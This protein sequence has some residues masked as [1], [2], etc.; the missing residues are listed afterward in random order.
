MPSPPAC[1]RQASRALSTRLDRLRQTFDHLHDQL[2]DAVAH[3]IGHTVA[4]AVREAVHC[5]LEQ[6]PTGYQSPAW[7]PPGVSSRN[8]LW[9]DEE[10]DPWADHTER[11]RAGD[12]TSS[13]DDSE[14]YKVTEPAKANLHRAVLVGCEAAAYWLRQ[15]W[16]QLPLLAAF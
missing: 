3:Q 8:P 15:R 4:G 11:W 16:G 6:A 14:S 5:L 9:D 10:A 2:R 7:R 13:V 12:R 1:R